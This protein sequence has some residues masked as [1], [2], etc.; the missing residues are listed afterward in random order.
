MSS[1]VYESLKCGKGRKLAEIDPTDIVESSKSWADKAAGSKRPL[2]YAPGTTDFVPKNR[3]KQKDCNKGGYY[4]IAPDTNSYPCFW[5]DTNCV[6]NYDANSAIDKPCNNREDQQNA[7][8]VFK[9]TPPGFQKLRD[10]IYYSNGETEENPSNADVYCKAESKCAGG[11]TN[12]SG[13]NTSFD[14][15]NKSCKITT[16][17]CNWEQKN[18]TSG[19]PDKKNQPACADSCKEILNNLKNPKCAAID[20]ETAEK[21]LNG[22]IQGTNP[23]RYDLSKN[24]KCIDTCVTTGYT[25]NDV[26]YAWCGTSGEGLPF[27]RGW[28]YC[29]AKCKGKN[30]NEKFKYLNDGSDKPTP[31]KTPA[32]QSQ[33]LTCSNGTLNTDDF[34]LSTYHIPPAKAGQFKNSVRKGNGWDTQNQFLC[35]KNMCIKWTGDTSDGKN[36]I[37]SCTVPEGQQPSNVS[38][39]CCSEYAKKIGYRYQTRSWNDIPT[40]CV[41][42]TTKGTNDVWFNTNANPSC[43]GQGEDCKGKT[44]GTFKVVNDKLADCKKKH[45]GHR[46]NKGSDNINIVIANS[47]GSDQPPHEYIDP[48]N[49]TSN[50]PGPL[51]QNPDSGSNN[52]NTGDQSGDQSGDSDQTPQSQ[53]P[54]DQTPPSQTPS[55]A[56]SSSVVVNPPP[57]SSNTLLYVG[58]GV[59]VLLLLLFLLYRFYKKRGISSQPIAPPIT[60]P[61]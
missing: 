25:E 54:S 10:A 8:Y 16:D 60:Q 15:S 31:G 26:K 2:C 41:E 17:Y 53:T 1:N 32:P 3:I 38:E 33:G 13:E 46:G 49:F 52:D 6:V 21:L 36:R 28:A 50:P 40:G 56:T 45:K 44:E 61:M 20:K 47:G 57:K 22:K 7:G 23:D 29:D 37:Y 14:T 9:D 39:S 19:A 18:T 55:G 4:A 5:D 59:V 24:P 51:N 58:I 35:R 48:L 11:N 43:I 27:Y 30:G 42:S 34:D 12:T